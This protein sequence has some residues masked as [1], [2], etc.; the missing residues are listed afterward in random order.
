M[1]RI[2]LAT[3]ITTLTISATAAPSK[4]IKHRFI[5]IDES[6]SQLHL[7]D[8]INPKNGWT[9]K[10]N[11]NSRDGQLIGK[12][13]LLLSHPKGYYEVNIKNGEIVKDYRAGGGVMTVRRAKDGRTF[14]GR[15]H[16]GITITILD[17]KDKQVGEINLSD[18][19]NLRLM[20]LTAKKTILLGANK[21]VVEVGFDGKVLRRFTIPGGKHIYKAVYLP[22]GQ[23]LVTAGYGG[24]IAFVDKDDNVIKK[25]GQDA[26]DQGETLGFFADFQV[27]RNGNIVITNWHGHGRKDSNKGAHLLEFDK[28]GKLVWK[29]HEPE[30]AGC[31]HGVIVID[32]YDIRKMHDDK[33]G[34]MSPTK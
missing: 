10:I 30:K 13:R 17:K 1:L 18:A 32:G 28:K 5:A 24:F 19:N 15:N 16:K 12:N 33:R 6:G 2:A 29:W 7:V 27:L 8:Q 31:L 23:M 9:K 3:L 25:F 20:R 4:P 34:F 21:D 14:I 22:N 26:K 11:G